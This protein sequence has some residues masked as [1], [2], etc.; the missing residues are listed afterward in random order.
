MQGQRFEEAQWWLGLF[1]FLRCLAELLRLGSLN[2]RRSTVVG[3]GLIF[4]CFFA[5]SRNQ[6][7]P[8]GSHSVHVCAGQSEKGKKKRENNNNKVFPLR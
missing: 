2:F 3:G 5:A 8:T 7:L 1:P 6:L 4:F